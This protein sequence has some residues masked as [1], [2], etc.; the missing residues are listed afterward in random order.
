MNSSILFSLLMYNSSNSK[1]SVL[2]KLVGFNNMS[3]L[4]YLMIK[5]YRP[6]F[7]YSFLKVY[8]K[9][10]IYKSLNLLIL[11]QFVIKLDGEVFKL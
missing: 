5:D 7:Y 8:I 3:K 1:I 6:P 11:C 10:I 9:G 2:I 4:T